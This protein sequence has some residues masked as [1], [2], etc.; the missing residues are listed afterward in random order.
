MEIACFS[1]FFLFLQIHAFQEN[2]SFFDFL[3][4]SVLLSVL[5]SVEDEL[6]V[7]AG[8]GG[9]STTGG[10]ATSTTGTGTEAAALAAAEA[11]AV[12]A[13]VVA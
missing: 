8:A 12:A 7:G 5:V 11:A 2:A 1:D 6:L 10:G 9:A 4:V 3:F 13:C